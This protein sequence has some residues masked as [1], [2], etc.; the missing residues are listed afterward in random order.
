MN[1]YLDSG[2]SNLYMIRPSQ[3]MTLTKF[4][5]RFF[6]ISLS[7]T[8]VIKKHEP[9]LFL[10]NQTFTLLA[11]IAVVCA[12]GGKVSALPGSSGPQNR[13]RRGC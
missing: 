6:F 12:A 4:S 2:K 9:L 8:C 11:H 13:L 10:L 3:N 7:Q 5:I 1:Y